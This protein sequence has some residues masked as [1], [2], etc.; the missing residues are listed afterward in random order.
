MTADDAATHISTRGLAYGLGGLAALTGGGYAYATGIEPYLFRTTAYRLS[1]KGWPDGLR[2]RVAVIADLHAHERFLGPAAL[3]QILEKVQAEKPDVILHLGDY[4]S[5]HRGAMTP[6]G[7]A[8][9]LGEARAPLGTYA[10]LGNHDWTDDLAVQ[11]HG[12]GLP[13]A[14]QALRA[15]G[16]TLLHG[17]AVP[18]ATPR[19]T[20]WL[21]GLPSEYAIRPGATRTRNGYLS[22]RMEQSHETMASTLR[23]VP[24]DANVL[25]MAHEPDVFALDLDPRIA[26]QVSGHTHGG[27]IRLF[28]WSPFIPSR[29]GMRY[30]Y[31]HVREDGR[32]LIVSAGL[33]S[34]CL[35]GRPVRLRATPEIVLVEIGS[36]ASPT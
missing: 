17:D 6:E 20:L 31:G 36:K 4:C 22:Q 29:Y 25:L 8:A 27:Q 34:Q 28:G 7:V 26:L 23:S 5:Q 30:A 14:A 9:I 2:L 15:A 12:E 19:G 18:L 32:D 13:R 21:A 16:I 1:P 35:F 10:I 33:G 11:H 3:R 24:E